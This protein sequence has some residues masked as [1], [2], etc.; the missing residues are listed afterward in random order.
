MRKSEARKGVFIMSE[1]SNLAVGACIGATAGA[2][3]G[4]VA[5]TKKAAK[6]LKPFLDEKGKESVDA[7][8]KFRQFFL[9]FSLFLGRLDDFIIDIGKITDIG[10]FV[11]DVA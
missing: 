10:Y 1:N 6:I 7:Y 2:G 5:G 11:T 8:I 4:I 3:V 9:S